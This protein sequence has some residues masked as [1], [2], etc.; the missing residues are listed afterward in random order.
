MVEMSIKRP[1]HHLFLVAGGTGG[2]I[3]PVFALAEILLLKGY[4]PHLI[5]DPRG[6]K[7]Q[8]SHTAL[9]IHQMYLARMNHSH[10]IKKLLGLL[11]LGLGFFQSL[12]WILRFQPVIVIGFG[13]YPTLPPMLAAIIL[14]RLH[15]IHEQNAVLGRVN[16]W[17]APWVRKIAI[18]FPHTL[19]LPPKQ[20]EKV[21]L[22]GLPVRNAIAALRYVPYQPLESQLRILVLGGSQGTKI[23]SEM[24]PDALS[25]LPPELR[26]R[27]H[28]TQQCRPEDINRVKKNY[29]TLDVS[30]ELASFFDDIS[31]HLAIAH[32]VIARSGA[33]T[34]AELMVTGRPAI[35]IPLPSAMDDHQT[36]NARWI[37]QAGAAWHLPQATLTSRTLADL[38]EDLFAK[39]AAL[40]FASEAM[41]SLGQIDAVDKLVELIEITK[42]TSSRWE[43]SYDQNKG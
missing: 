4:V 16:R 30:S 40:M 35:L 31:K 2:H 24:I 22:T 21:V 3:F 11:S 28:M 38:I 1:Q 33:S 14:K 19:K 26:K 13:G 20:K 34:C 17:L 42:D 25:H 37:A 15:I 18:S 8:K 7:I 10:L 29:R 36:E 43:F 5:T 39:P 27:L 6:S 32:L 12:L 41:R 23:F 9:M